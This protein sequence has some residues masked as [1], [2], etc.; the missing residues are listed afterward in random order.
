MISRNY[1]LS[2]LFLLLFLTGCAAGGTAVSAPDTYQPTPADIGGKWKSE[3]AFYIIFD[4]QSGTFSAS[5]N[6]DAAEAKQGILGSF[7]LE[8]GRLSLI[9]DAAS[10]SCP[11]VEGLFEAVMTAEGR[12]RLSIIKDGCLYRVEGMFQGGQ[13]GY[14]LLEF[15]RR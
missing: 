9:E 15:Q 4:E 7:M 1:L 10:E 2:A 14:R 8:N 5:N 12:L 6:E 3:R 11:G 13:G